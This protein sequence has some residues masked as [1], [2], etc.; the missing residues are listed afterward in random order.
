MVIKSTG[1]EE[2]KILVTVS[3]RADGM[4]LSSFVIPKRKD[5]PVA[6]Y[7]NALKENG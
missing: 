1:Y 6:L 3:V 2:L 5:Y 4:K 7:S